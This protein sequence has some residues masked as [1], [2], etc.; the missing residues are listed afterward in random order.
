MRG[1]GILPNPDRDSAPYWAALA[2]GR[3]EVQQCDDCG[4]WTWPPRPVCSGC[5]GES[6]TWRPACGTGEVHGWVVTHQVYAPSL[7]PLV[8]FTVVLVRL[9]E[10][11]D[12]LVP[13]RLLSDVEVHQGLRVRAVPT[14]VGDDLGTLEWEAM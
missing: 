11:P 13:G 7:A 6:L 8:P 14:A 5:H 4:H 3:L 9:D 1:I 10:Q 2:E 12:L